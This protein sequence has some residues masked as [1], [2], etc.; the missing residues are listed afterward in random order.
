MQWAV[1]AWLYKKGDV[2]CLRNLRD[3]VRCTSHSG[4]LTHNTVGFFLFYFGKR[5]AE[6]RGVVFNLIKFYVSVV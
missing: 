4:L 3:C 5:F 2:L 6:S 1:S